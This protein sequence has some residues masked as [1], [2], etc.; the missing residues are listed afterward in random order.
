MLAYTGDYLSYYQDAVA[1]EAYLDTARLRISVRRHTRLVDYFMHEGCNARVWICVETQE[2][3][4]LAAEDFYFITG[5]AKTADL[6][7]NIIDEN[8]LDKLNISPND[9]DVFEPLVEDKSKEIQFYKAHNEIRFYT[10]GNAECCL[11]RGAT[12]ATL[13]DEWV[14]V[15]TPT[16]PN[17]ASGKIR[18]DRQRG[19]RAG[20]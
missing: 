17:G 2:D 3:T 8:S 15:S 7:S 12:G 20:R 14:K 10:W 18:G 13:L 11:P 19:R 16:P 9:Y 4:Q 6:D 1:A 5:S